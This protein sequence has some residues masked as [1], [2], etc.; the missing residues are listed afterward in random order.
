MKVVDVRARLI[1]FLAAIHCSYPQVVL[2]EPCKRLLLAGPEEAQPLMWK[3]KGSERLTGVFVEV[4][5]DAFRAINI[6]VETKPYPWVRAQATVKAGNADLLAGYITEERQT[7][8][9]YVFPPLL[10]DKVAVFVKKERSFNYQRWGDLK[11]LRGITQRGNSYGAEFDEYAQDNLN[12]H[13]VDK[14]E[15]MFRLLNAGR[16]RYAVYTYA[17]G[18]IE[19]ESLGLSDNIFSL[20]NYVSSENGLYYA[21]SK[22]SPCKKYI[23]YL[24]EKIKQ[25]V[26]EKRPERLLAKYLEIW[27]TQYRPQ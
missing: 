12:I 16:Y 20:P 25:Y 17:A 3:T 7:Y 6:P 1:L 19:L 4:L 15:Q 21:F 5:E 23:P 22:K 13:N 26:A 10:Y 9:D 11:G 8:M 27:K 18:V 24:S 2:A 14:V